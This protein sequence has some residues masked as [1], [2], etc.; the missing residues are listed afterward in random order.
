MGYVPA[1][2]RREALL[3]A[4]VRV[5][6]REGVAR[7]TTRRI[8]A[9]AGAPLASVHY[10]FRSRE[11]LLGLVAE[12]LTQELLDTAAP[13]LRPGIG[14]LDVLHEGIRALWRLVE[15]DPGKQLALYEL[16]LYALRTEGLAG[17]AARQYGAYLQAARMFLEGVFD[18]LG[19]RATAPV[20]LLARWLTATVD[21][22]MLTY[23]VDRDRQAALDVLDAF[24]ATLA[25]HLTPTG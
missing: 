20:E 9:E 2:E 11:E 21:G 13:S 25:S 16:T 8:A 5:M 10:C 18:R 3:A 1:D 17:L 6:S 15:E 22:V 19:L 12:R 7:A 23:T 24:A 4:A 14:L